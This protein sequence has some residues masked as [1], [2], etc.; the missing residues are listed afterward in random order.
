MLLTGTC[1]GCVNF[2]SLFLALGETLE[3]HM[4]G[5]SSL[6]VTNDVSVAYDITHRAKHFSLQEES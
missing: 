2:L 6:L 1:N 5:N 4:E 3:A